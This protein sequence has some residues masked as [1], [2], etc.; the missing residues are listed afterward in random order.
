V[1]VNARPA[2]NGGSPM[3]PGRTTWSDVIA[4]EAA[5]LEQRRGLTDPPPA[6]VGLAI[7]GGGIRSATFA[8]GVLE[9]LKQTGVLKAIDYLSTV[10]GGGFIG[11][12]LSANCKRNADWPE[13]RTDWRASIAYLRRYSN[14]LSPS[15]GFLS[16]DTWSMATVWFR[17]TLLIQTTAIIAI[18]CALLA[19]RPLFE[20]FRHWPQSGNFRWATVVLFVL[21]IVGIAGNQLRLTG[22][23]GGRLLRASSWPLSLAAAIACLVAAWAYGWWMDFDPFHGGEVSYA[24]TAPVALLLVLAG[25]ALQ[26]AAVRLVASVWPDDDPPQ[27]INYTQNWVQAVVVVPLVTAGFLVAAVLWGEAIGT[28][29][30]VGLNTLSTYGA[31]VGSAWRYWPFPL[32]VVFVSVWLVAFCSIE[33]RRTIS[34]LLT[35]LLAPAAAVPVLHAVLCGV[36][37]LFH[38]WAADPGSG[39][40]RAFVW[41][42]PLVALAFVLAIVVLIGMM[43]RESNED[44]REWWSRLA[45]WLGIYAAAWLIVAITGVYATPWVRWT[46]AQ[47]PLTAL[48]A[49]AGWLGTV[50]AGLMAGNSSSTD[51]R[52]KRTVSGTIK[53]VL[54][55]VGPFVFIAGLLIGVAYGLDA[56]IHANSG[57]EWGDVGRTA[58]AQHAPFFNASMVALLACIGALLLL[59]ARVDINEFSLNAFYRNRLVRCYLGATRRRREPQNF[60]GFDGGDDM[61]LAALAEGGLSGPLH[62]VN[63][64][65]NLG[66]SSDL[67][68]HTRHSAAFMLTPFHCG[69]TYASHDLRSRD[70]ELG[71]VPTSRYGGARGG[72][73]LGQ[74]IAVSGAAASPNMGYHTSPVTAFLLTL[75]NVRLGWWFPNPS[76]AKA[77]LPSP[78]FSLRYLLAELFGGATDRSRFV[79]ISDGG[80]FENLAAYELVRRRCPVIIL[81]DGEC[82]AQ[83]TFEGL[84]TLIRMCEVDFGAR[85][86]IDVSELRMAE[87]PWSRARWA[88][89]AISYDD[90]TPDGVLV[91]LKASM[92]GAEDTSVLQYKA[93]HPTFPHESTGNQFYGEDQFESY[94]RLG[95]A[96]AVDVFQSFDARDGIITFANQ[97]LARTADARRAREDG[98]GGRLDK[99][100]HDY[101]SL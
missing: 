81:I 51:G 88:V 25:F 59:A 89:G 22:K 60:T 95:Q 72:P 93:S 3:R 33:G 84:G 77:E 20:L 26:P 75:F 80:H 19:P 94:R 12:W 87:T 57:N 6:R 46:Q 9:A 32:S 101:G 7:S 86:T 99:V 73:T 71:F 8:L 92:T 55:A 74:A 78:P 37:L 68:L 29:G 45:A 70:T 49:S 42:P 31:L 91:Y 47:H 96:I 64:A 85:I 48:W 15:V 54:A 63:C 44:V 100:F 65:L 14:Y 66:G 5:A 23:R 76:Q 34:G 69:S 35:A 24:Q 16:A 90:G 53:E 61:P 18:A 13:P 43:S 56:L 36:M 2:R 50:A 17:N 4:R 83:M 40:W 41:G 28:P 97:L 11:A 62:I 79:M 1:T 38:R 39:A 21:G 27:Q 98:R 30:V 67:S 82:D 52:S 58:H 10:S